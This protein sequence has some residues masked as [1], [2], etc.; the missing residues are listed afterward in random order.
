M[1]LRYE[2][3]GLEGAVLN[4]QRWTRSGSPRKRT[5]RETKRLLVQE[6]KANPRQGELTS[7][8]S[9]EP[10]LSFSRHSS[11]PCCNINSRSRV[12]HHRPSP[13]LLRAGSPTALGN[14]AQPRQEGN[15]GSD[16]K[17]AC[18]CL[19]INKYAL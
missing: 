3:A 5:D 11:L 14:T 9:H 7:K 2:V 12:C 13:P 19:E 10:I 15:G 18:L 6:H 17:A 1:S 4:I 16:P 8:H